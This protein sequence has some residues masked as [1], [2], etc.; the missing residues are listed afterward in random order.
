MLVNILISKYQNLL[1]DIF[2]KYIHITENNN[3]YFKFSKIVDCEIKEIIS[4]FNVLVDE[5]KD[6]F[7]DIFENDVESI[8]YALDKELFGYIKDIFEKVSALLGIK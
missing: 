2:I 1:R 8:L 5:R 3:E 6:T 7:K 4:A